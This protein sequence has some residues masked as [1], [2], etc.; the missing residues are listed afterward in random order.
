VAN[1]PGN[2]HI[3]SREEL[4]EFTRRLSMLSADGVEEVY[5]TAHNDCRLDGK[6]VP[7]PPPFSS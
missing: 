7:P 5:R 6:R 1:R 4:A 3:M 2:K